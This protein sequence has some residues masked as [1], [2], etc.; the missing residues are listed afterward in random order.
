MTVK[1]S[2]VRWA[3]YKKFEGPMYPGKIP[4]SV[5]PNPDFGDKCV[6]IVAAAE[7]GKYDAVNMYDSCILTVGIVQAC[8]RLH[9]LSR[10]LGACSAG[11]GAIRKVLSGLPVPLDFR[12]NGSGSWKFFF[13][14]GRGEVDTDDKMRTAFL[15]GSSG[16][17]G[18]WSD[19]QKSHARAVAAAFAEMWEDPVLKD[20]QR[21]YVKPRLNA[22]VMAGTRAALW[23]DPGTDGWSGALKASVMSFSVNIPATTDKLFLQAFND[24]RWKTLDGAGRFALAMGHMVVGSQIATWPH[25]YEGIYGP[26]EEL[27]GVDIPRLSELRDIVGQAQPPSDPALWSTA[28]VQKFLVASGYDL[29]PAG[30]DGIYGPKTKAAVAA[31][32]ASAGIPPTGTVDLA[33]KAAITAARSRSI[34]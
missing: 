13:L 15:G 30:A 34:P 6:R 7:G 3:K 17:V 26:I 22:F 23:T 12:Q 1:P 19:S 2:E 31:F 20:G 33:T 9:E 5:P 14:D 29:G 24:P 18:Q 32:Q 21:E 11:L 10:M 8:G 16:E 25:R 27:F 28:S 4:Y